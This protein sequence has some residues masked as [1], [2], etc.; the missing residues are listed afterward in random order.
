MSENICYKTF[1]RC[2]MV[3]M[4]MMPMD[5]NEDVGGNNGN[6]DGGR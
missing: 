4:G 2:K 5:D 1:N 6:V 3:V